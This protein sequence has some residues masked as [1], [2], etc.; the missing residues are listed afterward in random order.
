MFFWV[1][2]VDTIDIDQKKSLKNLWDSFLEKKELWDFRHSF[3]KPSFLRKRPKFE[4]LKK[5][6]SLDSNMSA[7]SDFLHRDGSIYIYRNI[8]N[9]SKIIIFVIHVVPV[10]KKKHSHIVLPCLIGCRIGWQTKQMLSD[11]IL[12]T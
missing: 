9:L 5:K 10:M 11:N 1:F 7:S 4:G 2:L 6:Q 12:E 8:L 3:K